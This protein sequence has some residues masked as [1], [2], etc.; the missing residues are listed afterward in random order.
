MV[1]LKKEKS[2]P[3]AVDK[4][5]SNEGS[6]TLGKPFTSCS[7][8]GYRITAV[9]ETG[10][11]TLEHVCGAWDLGT[12]GDLRDGEAWTLSMGRQGAWG[13]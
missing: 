3:Q 4:N 1:K 5:T 7:K 12:Q 13:R 10:T 11:R 8:S 9:H 6:H 2:C